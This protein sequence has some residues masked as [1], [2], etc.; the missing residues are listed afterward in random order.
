MLSVLASRV[1]LEHNSSELYLYC[2]KD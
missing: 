2:F 1:L